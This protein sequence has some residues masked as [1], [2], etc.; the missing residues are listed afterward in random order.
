MALGTYGAVQTRGWLLDYRGWNVGLPVFIFA[1]F[2]ALAFY[3]SNIARPADLLI[4][5]E[6]EMR[7]VTWPTVAEVFGATL[8][9]IVVTLMMGFYLFAL[10]YL[11][12]YG[13]LRLLGMTPR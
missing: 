10:D 12:S 8:V 5:T 11:I 9:V 13:P 4:E 7:K 3:L 2:A 6:I 1:V